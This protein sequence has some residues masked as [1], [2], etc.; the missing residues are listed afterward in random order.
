MKILFIT[1][2]SLS[3]FAAF[4]PSNA[5]SYKGIDSDQ[6]ECEL[7]I[8]K[9]MNSKNVYRLIINQ[10]EEYIIQSKGI[11]FNNTDKII[12]MS[13][14]VS[15][16]NGIHKLVVTSKPN[17]KL[18]YKIIDIDKVHFTKKTYQCSDLKLN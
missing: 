4:N 8:V 14:K 1:I 7:E 3:S 15:S 16:L 10:S 2:F 13:A 6:L 17:G 5:K 12:K 18:S 11:N 9:H